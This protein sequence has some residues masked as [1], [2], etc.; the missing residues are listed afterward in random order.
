MN[1]IEVLFLGSGDAFGS[2][3]RFQACISVRTPSDRFLLDCGASSLIAMKRARIDPREV[4]KIL[5]SHLH[6]DHFGGIP[7]FV[8]DAQLVTK[9]TGPLTIVGPPGLRERVTAAMEVLFPGSAGARRDFDLR[10]VELPPRTGTAIDGID[11]T[12][13]P[14]INSSGAIPYA[15]RVDVAGRVIAYS[16]DTEWT[17]ALVEAA[18]GA[19]LFVCEA[20]FFDRKVKGHL[21]YAT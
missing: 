4:S 3:G 7:F 11:I 19:D 15:L 17:P 18:R 21:D 8:L 16:G 12:A 6:G 5:V 2:G 1:P 13:F 9:R 20:Y 14:V 10:F